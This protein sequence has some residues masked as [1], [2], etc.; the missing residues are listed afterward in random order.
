MTLRSLAGRGL[1]RLRH[2]LRSFMGQLRRPEGPFAPRYTLED[3]SQVTLYCDD[4]DLFPDYRP[5]RTLVPSDRREARV[6]LIATGLNEAGSLP[7]WLESVVNQTRPPDEVVLV[8]GGS[9]D[10]SLEILQ[11]FVLDSP[12]PV[13]VISR[14]GANIAEGRNL[15]IRHA[16][17]PV[18]ACTDFGCRLHPDWLEKLITPFEDDPRTEVSAGW[19]RALS[20]GRPARRLGWAHLPEVDPQEYLPSSRSVAYRKD[21]WALAGGYPTWLSLTGEDTYFSAELKRICRHWAFVPEAVVD[22]DAPD[23]PQA[24]W[25]KIR[26]WSVG[27]GES[28][29][30]P[31]FAWWSLIRLTTVPLMTL[32]VAAFAIPAWLLGLISGAAAALVVALAAVCAFW[33]AYRGVYRVIAAPGDLPWEIGAE[34]AR[35][36]GFLEGVRRRP[37]ASAR[38]YREAPGLVLVLSVVPI[39]DTGGGARSSQLALELLR[40]GY[41]VA[42]IN[43]FPKYETVELDLEIRHPNLITRPVDAFN[44]QRFER[45]VARH[46]EDKPLVAVVEL[47]SPAFLPILDAV[48]ARGGVVVYDLLDDWQTSLGGH[49]YDPGVEREIIDRSQILVATAP[50]LADRLGRLTGRPVALL[51][52][53]VNRRLFDPDRPHRRPDDL[54]EAEWHALY[55][56]ALWGDWL[57]WELL[58]AL[59]RA[60]PEAAV[61]AIGDY[62]GQ[63]PDPPANLHF[64]GLKPQQSLPAYLAHIEVAIVPWR[65]SPVT[66]AT[67]PLKV[68]EYLAME[69]PVVAPDLQPLRGIP[70]VSLAQD[71]GDFIKKVGEQREAELPVEM[72]RRYVDRNDWQ[73][74][75]DELLGLVRSHASPTEADRP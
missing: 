54:P 61:V 7:A 48:R 10:R 66:E 56:G 16:R 27:D 50:A 37:E 68:Y 75:V 25:R 36:D 35:V 34:F 3:Y 62:A 67:S 40:R 65:V 4:P 73:A 74:R 9:Q 26:A 1:G 24:Y 70:G 5:R 71:W 38:R 17:G 33:I 46:L 19:F 72:I 20:G 49:W 45:D 15:A 31:Q 28:G 51:P 55:I 18:I 57:D 21:A 42:L 41:V 44:W 53:A 58:T 22:W 47:P 23:T 64:L 30:F 39:D 8:D 60:Y 69:K 43:R 52:N 32:A 29:A 2:L 11:S 59:A 6:S 14:P 12:F 13:K 63:C